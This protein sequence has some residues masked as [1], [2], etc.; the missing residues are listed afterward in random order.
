NRP[1][2]DP[3]GDRVNQFEPMVGAANGIEIFGKSR[4]VIRHIQA[5]EPIGAPEDD[6][7]I[8]GAM[9]ALVTDRLIHNNRKLIRSFFSE[10]LSSRV[11]L[12]SDQGTRL[13]HRQKPS[14]YLPYIYL[15]GI[16]PVS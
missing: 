11:H 8:V 13:K 6:L 15:Q 2:K 5:A 12:T 14:E 4:S 16:G 1:F 9:L 3:S 10:L 7:H